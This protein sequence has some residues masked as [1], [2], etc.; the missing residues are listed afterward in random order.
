MYSIIKIYTGKNKNAISLEMLTSVTRIW[1]FFPQAA[2]PYTFGQAPAAQ[3]WPVAGEK[4]I[5]AQ[6]GKAAG[7]TYTDL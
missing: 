5:L 2:Y 7:F 4:T 3:T 1:T 6:V